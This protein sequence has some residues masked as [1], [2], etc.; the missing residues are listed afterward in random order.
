MQLDSPTFSTTFPHLSTEIPSLS[1]KLLEKNWEKPGAIALGNV[2]T[3]LSVLAL[4]N[5]KVV[6]GGEFWKLGLCALSRYV[7]FGKIGQ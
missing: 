4:S 1:T 3:R 7:L 2:N 5:A 6:G